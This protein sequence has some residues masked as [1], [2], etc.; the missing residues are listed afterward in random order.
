MS[1]EYT[2]ILI[3]W[4]VT[5]VSLV[6]FI[7]RD[8][9]REAQVAFLFK[10]AI[11]WVF[12]LAVVELRLIEYPVRLFPHAN[13]TSFTFE[14]F[15][16]PSLSAIFNVNYPKN[17]RPFL[18]FMYYFYFC[19]TFTVLEVIVERYTNV[20]TYIH[21]TWYITWITLFI[22]FYMSRKY[23]VWFFRLKQND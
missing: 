4:I 19:T 5:I 8:K 10:Q 3:G 2:I 23:Y 6:R 15:I 1:I 11:T 9:I 14:C 22:T 12:G 20:L 13:G 7:P 17:K 18:Q 16:Y 21:W